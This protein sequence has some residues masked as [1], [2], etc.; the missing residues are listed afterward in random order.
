MNI[1]QQIL[2]VSSQFKAPSRSVH[3]SEKK[4]PKLHP[5]VSCCTELQ[6]VNCRKAFQQ[7][8]HK[9]RIAVIASIAFAIYLF[10]TCLLLLFYVRVS[11]D[12]DNKCSLVKLYPIIFYIISR[13][14][15]KRCQL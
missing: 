4:P 13:M 14:K 1:I 5:T 10:I 6:R 15:R 3:L 7:E 9:S 8:R 11:F 2:H 12:H